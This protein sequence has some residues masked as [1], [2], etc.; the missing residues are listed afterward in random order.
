MYNFQ[1]FETIRYF[2]QNIFGGKITLVN[3]DEYQYNLLVEIISFKKK[4]ETKSKEKE[5]QIHT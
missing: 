2:A 1:Q 3:A 5:K 4:N